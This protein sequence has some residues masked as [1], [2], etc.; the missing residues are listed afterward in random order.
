M[1]LPRMD[2]LRKGLR[3][4][5][6]RRD[7]RWLMGAQFLAQAGD[8]I[9]QTALAKLIVFGGQKGFDL[10]GA[11]DPDELLR[12]ALY[13]FIPYTIISPFLGVVMDRW[14]RRHLLMVA[15]GFRALVVALIALIGTAEVGDFPLFA[16]FVLSLAS[17]RIVLATKAAAMPATLGI[18]DSEGSSRLVEANGVSQLGGAMFQLGGAGA[19]F[20]AATVLEAEPIAL[21]G[22]LVYLAGAFSASLI[23]RA[24]R[25]REASRLWVEIVGVVRQIGL[26]LAAVGRSPKASASIS[27]Y[28][29][30]R[31][32]WSFTIVGISFAARDL[33]ES[34]LKVVLLTGGAGAI[35]AVLGFVTSQRL[36][37]RFSTTGYLVL[38]SSALA[39]VAVTLL[40][41]FDTQIS[42]AIMTFFLGL[43]FFVGK[44]TLD[45]MVQEA[46]GDDFRG[47]AFSLY[48]IA[49]NLAWVLAAAI[50]KVAYT[51][52]Q[53]GLLIS[54][55]GAVFLGGLVV[56]MGWYRR[57]GLLDQNLRTEPANV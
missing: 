44:I 5:S 6:E 24:G 25:T 3:L 56:L 33:V 42:L 16:A 40:G 48:D 14:N 18:E 50:L 27:T 52:D 54:A 8:G 46:L 9:V 2:T 7:F 1:V 12:I 13:I 51:P 4:L 47:R 20:V 49:Y 41:I 57:A 43:G 15:N 34:D 28:F 26:G 31:V 29:W 39:G 23:E 19:A 32:L 45:T 35:G 11:R 17:T 22:A 55:G 21:V 10:E 30:L 38:T 36:L 37:E 53:R